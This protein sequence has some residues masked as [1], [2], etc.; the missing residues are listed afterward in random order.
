MAVRPVCARHLLIYTAMAVSSGVPAAA[1]YADPVT[2]EVANRVGIMRYCTAR[3]LATAR[4]VANADNVLHNRATLPPPDQ[5][6]AVENLGEQGTVLAAGQQFMLPDLAK[7]QNLSLADMCG[8]IAS[9]S[10]IAA[11]LIGKE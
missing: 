7:Q 10:A 9:S 1:Q 6:K 11:G 2:L 8:T 4:D 3:G 5:I